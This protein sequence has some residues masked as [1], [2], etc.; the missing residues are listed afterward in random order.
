[1]MKGV[2]NPYLKSSDGGWQIDPKGLR[3]TLNEIYDRYQIPLMIV[4][5]GLGAYDEKAVDGKIH[6][7]YRIDY[8]RQHI[9]Q[10]SE[11]ADDGVDLIGYTPW[12]CIDLV[13]ASTG[14]MA[15]RYGKIYVNKFDD[16]SGDLSRERKDSFYW[17]QKVIAINGTDLTCSFN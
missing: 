9:Q 3:Y 4:E 12:G 8:L 10:M 14:E 6:D 16:G 5:N 11:A 7:D 2:K 15:K 13:S 1:M 17:Y